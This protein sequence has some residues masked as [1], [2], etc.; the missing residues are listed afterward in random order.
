ME[1]QQAQLIFRILLVLFIICTFLG[2]YFGVSKKGNANLP[3]ILGVVAL[4]LFVGAV[5][6]VFNSVKALPN[7]DKDVVVNSSIYRDISLIISIGLRLVIISVMAALVGYLWKKSN[8]YPK[9]TGIHIHRLLL[10]I[11]MVGIVVF[12]INEIIQCV[13][14]FEYRELIPFGN[15][16]AFF[17]GGFLYLLVCSIVAAAALPEG[18]PNL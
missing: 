6:T 14:S 16:S 18:K 13:N 11:G 5:V 17:A 8:S 1:A 4:A 12:A 9:I 7:L 3:L 15:Y 10:V 2:L